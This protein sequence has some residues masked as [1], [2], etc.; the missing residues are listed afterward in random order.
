MKFK[1]FPLRMVILTS[2]PL[3]AFQYPFSLFGSEDRFGL[4]VATSNC[5]WREA[6]CW[7]EGRD[8][9]VGC[10]AC[11]ATESGGL[12]GSCEEAVRTGNSTT[13]LANS[14]FAAT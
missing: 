6:V 5:G 2:S 12:L 9:I 1:R 4:T 3:T 8:A 14:A 7:T 10:E 11:G 13:K